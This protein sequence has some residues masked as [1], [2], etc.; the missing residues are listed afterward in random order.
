[1]NE[2][3]FRSFLK[4]ALFETEQIRDVHSFIDAD[5][6]TTNQMLVVRMNDNSEFQITIRR[7]RRSP[8]ETLDE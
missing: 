8:T 2:T 6:L 4:D 1:M 5:L 7:S 3:D